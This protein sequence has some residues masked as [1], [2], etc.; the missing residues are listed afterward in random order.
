[1]VSSQHSS[2]QHSSGARSARPGG[3]PGGSKAALVVADAERLLAEALALALT[4]RG[5]RV[6]ATAT[7]R[8]GVVRAVLAHRPDACVLDLRLSDGRALD[9]I[10]LIHRSAPEVR[11]LALSR[12]PDPGSVELAVAAGAAGYLSK[13]QGI[14]V[15]DRALTRIG[16]GE[17]FVEPALAL[18]AARLARS[19]RGTG[20]D[21]LRWLTH[22]ELEVLRRLTE[23]DGTVEIARALSMTTNTARTHVQNVLD[24]LG[25]HSRLEAVA[26]ANRLGAELHPN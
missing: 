2:G 5:Y 6:R 4:G 17:L 12:D 16:A 24:K 3:S 14:E 8:S 25:V 21:S 19:R 9:S 15:L 13:D 10:E 18:E 11:I 7:S 23:G 22:R 20:P 1:M 26:L